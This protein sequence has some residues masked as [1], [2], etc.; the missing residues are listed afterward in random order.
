M[1]AFVDDRPLTDI[2]AEY[3]KYL[4]ERCLNSNLTPEDVRLYWLR[5]AVDYSIL[6][7]IEGNFLTIPATSALSERVFSI[8]SDI[9]TR[10]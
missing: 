8:S 4:R 6:S 1:R 5:K 7:Q 3:I 2:T 10:K 9:L